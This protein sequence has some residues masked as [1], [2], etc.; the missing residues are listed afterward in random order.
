M[1]E[2]KKCLSGT[3]LS[4]TSLM[5][6]LKNME[7]K[8]GFGEILNII[9][10][11]YDCRKSSLIETA[12][13]HNVEISSEFWRNFELIKECYP[14]LKLKNDTF[15]SPRYLV[16]K[17]SIYTDEY[18]EQNINNDTGVGQLL[19]FEFKDHY[20][21]SNNDIN[22][23]FFSF[24]ETTTDTSFYTEIAEKDLLTEN[25][26]NN[27]REKQ[28]LFNTCL[29]NFG[30]NVELEIQKMHS[31][32]FLFKRISEYNLD[33]YEK[34]IKEYES[35]FE[36]YY[37]G[38]D[39]FFISK[40]FK[41]IHRENP[42]LEALFKLFKI[43]YDNRKNIDYCYDEVSRTVSNVDKIY[44]KMSEWDNFFW[45]NLNDL[46]IDGTALAGGTT[47]REDL[48]P[49]CKRDF[50]LMIRRYI[51]TNF[52]NEVSLD[53][54]SINEKMYL[55]SYLKEESRKFIGIV[56]RFCIN[57]YLYSKKKYLYKNALKI[58]KQDFYKIKID[59]EY[60]EE[61]F[62][63]F[64]DYINITNEISEITDY[65]YLGIPL[66][67]CSRIISKFNTFSYINLKYFIQLLTIGG[68]FTIFIDRKST[69]YNYNNIKYILSGTGDP[70]QVDNVVSGTLIPL[71]ILFENN[72][73]VKYKNSYIKIT[74][75]L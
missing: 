10:V 15:D 28:V 5:S 43:V 46:N 65:R 49:I 7:D 45:D 3:S 17:N 20:N 74:K 26:I 38:G 44:L 24:I 29:N 72:I 70:P 41:E 25:N 21:F 8:D 66:N 32:T 36:N 75:S 4:G 23:V 13:F 62:S 68:K 19:D 27:L 9:L 52:F 11:I 33:F 69:M 39:I 51:L 64:S 48:P 58:P 34:N 42:N 35:F 59:N 31:L 37:F 54:V 53:E 57:N 63:D 22:R 40:T 6:I 56:S 47:S 16:Y 18:V 12:N 61:Y 67:S 50:N 14:D 71:T 73:N 55:I 1:S 30:Y 60:D 2:L